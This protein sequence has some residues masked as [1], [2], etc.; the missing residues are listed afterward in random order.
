MVKP[1]KSWLCVT[2]VMILSACGQTNADADSGTV[3]I[4]A[5]ASLADPFKE[6]EHQLA[7]RHPEV[8][9]V[10]SFGPS[11]G[12]VEQVVAGAPADLLAT[13]DETTMQDAVRA[14]VIAGDPVPFAQ[15]TLVLITPDENPGDVESVGDLERDDLRVALC[16][17]QVPCGAAAEQVLDAAGITPS[18]D[19]YGTDVTATTALVTLGEV[20]AA[21]VY[22]T[23]AAAAAEDV[24]VIDV[25]GAEH[26][27]NEYFIANIED[28]A[29][30]EQAQLALDAIL[31]DLGRAIL[32]DAGFG[33]P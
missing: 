10:F 1:A 11:S 17:P 23:D 22:R 33:L 5:A 29:N 20:D 14:G 4:M 7:E 26:V 15:N 21:L 25:P 31:G 3:T 19:T 12:L 9:V 27:E 24:Q 28:A 8:D 13:A 2:A 30:P 16:E 32:A 6:L 18:V